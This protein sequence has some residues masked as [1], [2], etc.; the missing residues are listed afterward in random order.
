MA[1]DGLDGLGGCKQPGRRVKGKERAG[2]KAL[3]YENAWYI[4]RREHCLGVV[5]YVRR[6]V[7]DKVRQVNWNQTLKAPRD[8]LGSLDLIHWIVRNSRRLL[9]GVQMI[10]AGL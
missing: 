9:G 7:G 10:H 5:R 6:V 1:E 3:G 4:L 2:A 8:L